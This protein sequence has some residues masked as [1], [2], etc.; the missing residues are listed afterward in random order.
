MSSTD[1]MIQFVERHGG[2]VLYRDVDS[3]TGVIKC[4]QEFDDLVDDY[5]YYLF[6]DYYNDVL[7]NSARAR[8]ED[9]V[10]EDQL[11]LALVDYL[12]GNAKVHRN[13]KFMDEKRK[14]F[15]EFDRVVVVHGGGEDV[16]D[17]VANVLE[18]SLSPQVKDVQQLLD[19]V[20]VFK[21]HVPT[22]TQFRSVG[23]IVPVLG[24]RMWSKEVIQECRAKSEARVLRGMSPIVRMQPSGKD[25]KV[26][27]GFATFARICLKRL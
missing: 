11:S 15:V 5:V 20:E 16:S 4:V 1:E 2:G 23:T 13:I 26:I 7:D 19:K 22:T 14:D 27:R 18:C 24:G 8:V 12:G 25:Y 21:L 3:V 17:S 10:L 9:R 6:N